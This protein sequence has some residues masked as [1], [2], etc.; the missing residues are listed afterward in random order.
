MVGGVGA[1]L[2]FNAVPPATG[3]PPIAFVNLD[4][5]IGPLGTYPYLELIA[6]FKASTDGSTLLSG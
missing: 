5:T 6:Y 1:T 3:S 2:T 4:S